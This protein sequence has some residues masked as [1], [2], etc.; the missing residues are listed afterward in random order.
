MTPACWRKELQ[1]DARDHE[2][3][4]YL[5][6]REEAEDSSHEAQSHQR[7]V[8]NAVLGVQGGQEA[9]VVAIARGSVGHARVAEKQ[10]KDAGEGGPHDEGGNGVAG[11]RT[12][13]GAGNFGD[14][15]HTQRSGFGG[16]GC[17]AP[18]RWQH[19]QIHGDVKR[20][21]DEHREQNGAGDGALGTPNLATE[22]RDVVVAPVAIGSEQSGLS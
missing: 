20:S 16:V 6:E 15:L 1:Q 9:E 5:S 3:G 8:G 11:P 17:G 4:D 2:H 21:D 7:A 22:E 14:K 13:A 18:Q 19:G 12:E 10:R